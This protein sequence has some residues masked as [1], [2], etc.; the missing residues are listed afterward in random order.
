MLNT[1]NSTELRNEI[2]LMIQYISKELINE[3]G[4]TKAQAIKMIKASGVEKSLIKDEMGFHDS[5]YNWAVSILTEQNDY[6]AL[7]KYLY[8]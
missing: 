5:P 3:F 8:H 6:E 7:E 4:K 2:D 1:N